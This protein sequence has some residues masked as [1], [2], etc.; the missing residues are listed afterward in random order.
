MFRAKDIMTTDVVSVAPEA[1]AREASALMLEN[2][3]S[4]LP[5]VDGEGVLVGVISEFDL[6]RL[7][8]NPEEEN[9]PVSQYMSRDVISVEKDAD[10][11]EVVDILRSRPIRRLPVMDHGELVGLISRPDLI[12]FVFTLR[13]RVNHKR[14]ESSKPASVME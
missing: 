7:V 9:E 12:R 2:G 1:T 6:L 14:Q 5:V 13:D 11:V 4:G 8:Y 10:L 3:F